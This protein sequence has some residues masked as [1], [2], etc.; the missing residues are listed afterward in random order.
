MVVPRML[1][2]SSSRRLRRQTFCEVLMHENLGRVRTRVKNGHR[3]VFPPFQILA[4]YA[5]PR[6]TVGTRGKLLLTQACWGEPARRV[7][8]ALFSSPFV[9]RRAG[10]TAS[11]FLNGVTEVHRRA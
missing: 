8:G 5:F 9:R 10:R 11:L 4:G 7:A 3:R 6:R 1:F 2:Q